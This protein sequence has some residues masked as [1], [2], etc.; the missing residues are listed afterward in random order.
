MWAR[1][2]QY[3]ESIGLEDDVYLDEFSN[4]NRIRLMGA[5]AMAM[6]EGIFSRQSH[7]PLTESTIRGTISLLIYLAITCVSWSSDTPVTLLAIYAHV[8]SERST[9]GQ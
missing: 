1:W 6:R 7:G 8:I 9:N 5:V 4:P 3:C 2:E